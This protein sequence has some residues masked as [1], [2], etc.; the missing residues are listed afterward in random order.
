MLSGSDKEEETRERREKYSSTNPKSRLCFVDIDQRGCNPQNQNSDI[1]HPHYQKVSF[2]IVVI[3]HFIYHFIIN[4]I[5][6]R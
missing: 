3:Y 5:L 4:S 2:F 1:N 6:G